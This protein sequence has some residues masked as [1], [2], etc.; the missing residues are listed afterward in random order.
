M[1]RRFE[2]AFKEDKLSEFDVRLVLEVLLSGF[3]I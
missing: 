3:G 2:K 1:I